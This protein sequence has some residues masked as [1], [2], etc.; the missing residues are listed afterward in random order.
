MPIAYRFYVMGDGDRILANEL[1][2][3]A[4]DTA[5]HSRGKALLAKTTGAKAV[6][7]WERARLVDRLE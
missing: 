3:F 4:D 6:E 1:M 5:A 7:V 2:S